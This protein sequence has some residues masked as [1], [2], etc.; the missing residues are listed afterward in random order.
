METILY[1]SFA[2]LTLAILLAW[3]RMAR[4]PTVVDRI[5]CF[6]AIAICVVGMIILLSIRWNS[7]LFLE[8]ILVVTLLG[9]MSGVAFVFYLNQTLEP[10]QQKPTTD[11]DP[12]KE[13]EQA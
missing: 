4:G 8:L 9:F 12:T 5:L 1:I 3:W 2:M 11:T 10:N 7:S 13:E 6:D